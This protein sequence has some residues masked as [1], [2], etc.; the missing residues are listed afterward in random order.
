MQMTAQLA[1]LKNQL[2]ESER[3]C[4]EALRKLLITREKANAAQKDNMDKEVSFF[5][6]HVGL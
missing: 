1:V 6:C 2:T 3:D 5:G 4:E